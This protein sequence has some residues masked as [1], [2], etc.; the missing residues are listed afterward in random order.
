MT[1]KLW[2]YSHLA[3]PLCLQRPLGEND[4][5]QSQ[6]D[7]DIRA[8]GARLP[9]TVFRSMLTPG[10]QVKPDDDGVCFSGLGTKAP[11]YKPHEALPPFSP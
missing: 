11:A 8:V 4:S 7:D 5:S 1:P 2:Y 9:V 6:A 10:L 3:R